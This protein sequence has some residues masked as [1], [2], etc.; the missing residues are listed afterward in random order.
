MEVRTGTKPGSD[1]EANVH[2]QLFGERGDTGVRKLLKSIA[3][4]P[5]DGSPAGTMF[6]LGK[7]WIHY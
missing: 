3:P 7:V 1:T 5:E 4:P 6:G 2:L